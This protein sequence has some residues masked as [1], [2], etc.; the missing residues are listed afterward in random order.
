MSLFNFSKDN[1]DIAIYL[2]D[3]ICKGM[4]SDRL[5]AVG[6]VI[7]EVSH[8]L[9]T[10]FKAINN[11]QISPLELE[12]QAEIDR[13]SVLALRMLNKGKNPS[14]LLGLLFNNLDI[15][16]ELSK[17]EYLR[18]KTAREIAGHFVKNS[19]H[20]NLLEAN[21]KKALKDLR[22]IYRLTGSKKLEEL[23]KY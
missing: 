19:L 16:S 8:V 17:D 20:Q 1:I 5:S 21:Y 15:I 14:R 7:E 9:Y 23:K 13:Y 4:V 10:V 18:Y 3:G 22:R 11:V 2:S 12:V 6:I